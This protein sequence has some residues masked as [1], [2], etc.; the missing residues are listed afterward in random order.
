MRQALSRLTEPHRL[1]LELAVYQE[2]PYAEISRVLDIPVGTVKS[3]MHNCVRAL[4][5]HMMEK[6]ERREEEHRLQDGEDLQAGQA[7]PADDRFPVK[8]SGTAG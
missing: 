7:G 8:A 2:M 4:R 1:V 3:R 6:K 5:A